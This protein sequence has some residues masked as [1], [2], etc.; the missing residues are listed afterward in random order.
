MKFSKLKRSLVVAAF[1][2]L[3]TVASSNQT[4]TLADDSEVITWRGNFVPCKPRICGNVT[5]NTATLSVQTGRV[6]V[7]SNGLVKIKLRRLASLQGE[8][9]MAN[10]TLDVYIGSWASGIFESYSGPIPLAVGTITTD[11]KGNFEGTIDTGGGVPFV[12]PAGSIVSA[13][14]ALNESNYRTEFVTGFQIP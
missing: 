9:V 4:P 5:G 6:T 10:K 7:Q 12:F 11:K 8:T 2:I 1:G 14:F 3:L 13:Q